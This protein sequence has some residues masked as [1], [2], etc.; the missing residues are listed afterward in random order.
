[1]LLTRRLAIGGIFSALVVLAL[2][3]SYLSPTADLAAFTISS[4]F[5]AIIVIESDI[6]TGLIAYIASSLLITFLFGIYY[7]IPFIFLFG[8]Y[9]IIKGLLEKKFNKIISYTIK[10]IFFAAL[11]AVSVII[12]QSQIN[13]SIENLKL[14]ITFIDL[15]MF[16][17]VWLI[18]IIVLV[19]LF[20]Y[21]LALSMLITVY[22]KRMKT[23]KIFS[24][25]K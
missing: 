13:Q 6:K 11:S 15:S 16:N 25:Y 8:L 21:D 12:Y 7:S 9:P 2:S 22:L 14:T 24:K 17:Y 5:I 23:N 3:F 19:V 10:G 1:M 18:F 20:I 4:L